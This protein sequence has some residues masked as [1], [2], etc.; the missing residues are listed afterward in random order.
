M[1]SL[2]SWHFSSVLR[3]LCQLALNY[4]IIIGSSNKWSFR[5][6]LVSGMT[7]SSTSCFLNKYSLWLDLCQNKNEKKYCGCVG[8]KTIMTESKLANVFRRQYAVLCITTR[9][10]RSVFLI[11]IS[12]FAGWSMF[13]RFQ[14]SLAWGCWAS[15]T[16]AGFQLAGER[17]IVSFRPP[18]GLIRLSMFFSHHLFSYLIL[19][20]VCPFRI[21]IFR[22]LFCAGSAH[23]RPTSPFPRCFT[24][25]LLMR[26]DSDPNSTEKSP[27]G[28]IARWCCCSPTTSIYWNPSGYY[29]PS[30][31]SWYCWACSSLDLSSLSNLPLLLLLLLLRW[32]ML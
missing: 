15:F 4:L 8:K 24:V 28:R 6:L 23:L 22:A 25:F 26:L 27:S 7:L 17:S 19:F 31:C 18:D 2:R 3:G 10:C 29:F 12:F 20:P 9:S 5:Y 14:F 16:L 11:L 13:I 1:T 32:F 30:D 21:L